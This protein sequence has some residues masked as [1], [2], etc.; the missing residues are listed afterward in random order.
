[1]NKRTMAVALVAGLAVAGSAQADVII[2]EIFYNLRGSE[3]GL[4]EWI[5]VHN[6]GSS[7]VD[8]SG[9]VYG[10]SQ[11]NTFAPGLP[12]GSV[13]PAGGTA[14]IVGQTASAFQGI[15]SAS[16]LVFST[17]SALVTLANSPSATNETVVIQDALGNTIDSVN[18]EDATNGW[19]DLTG[20]GFS[21]VIVP[22]NPGALTAAGNDI[23]S[24][25][26]I[27]SVGVFGAYEALT[28]NPG[29]SN[30][31][32]KDVASPGVIPTPGAAALLA[33]GAVAGVRRRR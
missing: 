26:A 32:L 2:T 20:E 16:V 1:M 24:N 15:W 9:W 23:G 29:I 13:L 31:T 22:T 14:V 33:L 30:A 19:P 17:G 11:D 6:T 7:A 25:W 21:F 12:S 8:M 18:F 4:T 5:E 3:G 28:L 10:D 27:A